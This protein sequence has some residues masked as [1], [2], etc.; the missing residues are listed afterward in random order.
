MLFAQLPPELIK[1]LP[2]GLS[3]SAII[4]VVI[5]FLRQ[6]DKSA[7][8]LKNLSEKFQDTIKDLQNTANKHIEDIYKQSTEARNAYQ[9]QI[10]KLMDSQIKLTRE[11]LETL[12]GLK[13]EIKDLSDV[14]NEQTPEK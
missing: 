3:S 6:Q 9:T 14:I 8:L 10:E 7:V 11:V 4:A 2:D 12:H 13:S 1:V 5:L